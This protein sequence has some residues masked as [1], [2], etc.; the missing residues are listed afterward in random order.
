MEQYKSSSTVYPQLIDRSSKKYVCVHSEIIEKVIIDDETEECI[1]YEFTVK[2][3][4][5]EEYLQ[6]EVEALKDMNLTLQLAL[7]ELFERG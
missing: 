6:I 7:I 5:K 4:T 2:K 3:Y 1:F